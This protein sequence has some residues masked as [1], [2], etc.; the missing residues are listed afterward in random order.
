MS[1][2]VSAEINKWAFQGRNLH[3][4]TNYAILLV[5]RDVYADE[6]LLGK[7]YNKQKPLEVTYVQAPEF[8]VTPHKSLS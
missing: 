1:Q 8:T 5:S 3:M 4:E 6:V 2:D 7:C